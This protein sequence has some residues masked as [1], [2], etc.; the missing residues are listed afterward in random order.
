[1]VNAHPETFLEVNLA[2]RANHHALSNPSR[3]SHPPRSAGAGG[4]LQSAEQCTGGHEIRR[5]EP[6]HQDVLGADRPCDSLGSQVGRAQAERDAD[7][8]GDQTGIGQWSQVGEDTRLRKMRFGVNFKPLGDP[9][10]TKEL[11]GGWSIRSF[12]GPG[13]AEAVRRLG[14]G[15]TISRTYRRYTSPRRSPPVEGRRSR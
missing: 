14:S 15:R 3:S 11:L 2:S 10:Q 13:S 4:A 5:A 1:M 9:P 7:G 12:F 6:Q 8:G